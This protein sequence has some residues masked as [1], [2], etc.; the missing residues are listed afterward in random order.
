MLATTASAA[1]E[2][3]GTDWSGSNVLLQQ[4]AGP[5]STGFWAPRGVTPC[6]NPSV[7][8]ADKI[9]VTTPD[10]L[11]VDA[12]GAAYVWRGPQDPCLFLI[13]RSVLAWAQSHPTDRVANEELC[14]D[15]LHER[16]HDA[17]LGH[18]HGGVMD[19]DSP[20]TPW[21]CVIWARSRAHAAAAR[22]VSR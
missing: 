16:G 21:D 1:I 14:A 13:R 8:I 15:V 12:D 9:T 22:T 6:G 20:A 17:G 2:S 7:G 3:T 5:V 18:T 11:A 19:T 10:G 4:L